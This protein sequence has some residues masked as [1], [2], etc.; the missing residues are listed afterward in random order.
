MLPGPEVKLAGKIQTEYESCGCSST[1]GLNEGRQ[2]GQNAMTNL[3]DWVLG[4][5]KGRM[6]RFLAWAWGQGVLHLH[7]AT[8]KTIELDFVELAVS[9]GYQMAV[10]GVGWVWGVMEPKTEPQGL[11]A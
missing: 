5:K 6:P 8:Q 10:P 2:N 7:R 9:M 3:M 1:G 11:V 4:K